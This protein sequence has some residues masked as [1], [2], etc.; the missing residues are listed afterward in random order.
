MHLLNKASITYK[1]NT[2]IIYQSGSGWLTVVAR[3]SFREKAF[4]RR[5]M[6]LID[7]KRIRNLD[8]T[9]FLIT[10]SSPWGW[11]G[12]NHKPFKKQQ[13]LVLTCLMYVKFMRRKLIIY[14]LEYSDYRLPLYCC[15]HVVSTDASFCL[16]QQF[17]V[18]IG[19]LHGTSNE[20]FN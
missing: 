17:L 19:S 9:Y 7:W 13:I 5:K 8:F 20:H 6:L 2:A 11:R 1:S 14:D 10:I 15:I 16:L 4:L 12:P 3:K 18:E